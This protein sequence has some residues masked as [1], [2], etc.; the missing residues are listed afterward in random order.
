MML[1]D[2]AHQRGLTNRRMHRKGRSEE[3]GVSEYI[4][5]HAAW[6]IVPERDLVGS[7]SVWVRA[8]YVSSR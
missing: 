1:D 3:Q 8:G 4:V 2:V 7:Y 6:C 5:G